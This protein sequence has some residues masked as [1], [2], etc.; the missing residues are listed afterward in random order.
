MSAP[1]VLRGFDPVSVVPQATLAKN[2]ALAAVG[3]DVKGTFRREPL[4][5]AKLGH[6]ALGYDLTA[7]SVHVDLEQALGSNS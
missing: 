7:F 2:G 1:L 4:G 3:S 5:H 6:T